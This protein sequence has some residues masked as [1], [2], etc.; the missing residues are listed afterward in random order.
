MYGTIWHEMI[1]VALTPYDTTWH[2]LIW[3]DM[4]QH[5]TFIRY[6]MKLYDIVQHETIRLQDDIK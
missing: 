6:D 1:Q 5:N 4:I 2:D 3:Y